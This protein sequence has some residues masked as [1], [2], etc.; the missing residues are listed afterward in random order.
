MDAIELMRTPTGEERERMGALLSEAAG[1]VARWQVASRIGDRDRQNAERG[2][3]HL[4]GMKRY[5][6]P[7]IE[8][9]PAIPGLS[10]PEK[11]MG[12]FESDPS[13]ALPTS[14]FREPVVLES[15]EQGRYER[16]KTVEAAALASLM[17][18][19]SEK[20][21]EFLRGETRDL[22]VDA[23]IR[24]ERREASPEGRTVTSIDRARFMALDVGLALQARAVSAGADATEP[25]PRMAA[26]GLPDVMDADI[27][28]TVASLSEADREAHGRGLPVSEEGSRSL[29]VLL[30][31][32]HDRDHRDFDRN[33]THALLHDRW[34]H[35]RNP[36]D[37]VT[38]RNT[39]VSFERS[40][41]VVRD[42]VM[43]FEDEIGIAR[44]RGPIEGVPLKQLEAEHRRTGGIRIASVLAGR[45]AEALGIGRDEPPA[46]AKGPEGVPDHVAAYM[47]ITGP[48][49]R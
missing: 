15:L 28:R 2:S 4:A 31:A 12:Y 47:R 23:A 40:S 29:A 18:K 32:A 26:L 24:S 36:L 42:Q 44:G 8:V 27:V 3:Y 1:Q 21:I 43:R 11:G 7:R 19:S 22:W 41:L 48:R 14:A 13:A 30:D 46:K 16:P 34:L 5:T 25:A 20:S 38:L 39:D 10:Q 45:A 35:H 17:A 6:S 49:G 9:L 33:A 37:V